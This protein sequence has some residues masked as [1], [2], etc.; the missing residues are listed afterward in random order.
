MK[1]E[2]LLLSPL[3]AHQIILLY[4][5]SSSTEWIHQSCF[6]LHLVFFALSFASVKSPSL[7]LM[8]CCLAVLITPRHALIDLWTSSPSLSAS[9]IF[10][11]LFH[12]TRLASNCAVISS[13]EVQ[14]P[15]CL[16]PESLHSSNYKPGGFSWNF[17]GNIIVSLEPKQVLRILELP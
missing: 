2:I 11:V 9:L 8:H 4:F 3:T 14:H 16:T 7:A 17:N 15:L 13:A 1:H 5:N 10:S 12:P 6:F